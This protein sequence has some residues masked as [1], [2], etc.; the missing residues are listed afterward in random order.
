MTRRTQVMTTTEMQT[1]VAQLRMVGTAVNPAPIV[2]LKIS[3][4]TVETVSIPGTAISRLVIVQGKQT[5]EKPSLAGF[6]LILKTEQLSTAT[7][8]RLQKNADIVTLTVITQHQTVDYDI[9][10]SPLSAG[11]LENVAQFWTVTSGQLEIATKI[12]RF[13]DWHEILAATANSAVLKK[14]A[15][16][17]SAKTSYSENECVV[18][19]QTIITAM[20]SE[21][22]EAVSTA[23][24]VVQRAPTNSAEWTILIYQPDEA[25]TTGHDVVELEAVSDAQLLAMPVRVAASTAQFW[26]GLAWLFYQRSLDRM[27]ETASR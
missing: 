12:R 9:P 27:T 8:D 4:K 16:T 15:V 18:L 5:T 13:Y 17:L 21:R 25:G 20:Q 14:M 1:L 10:W 7:I 22:A 24:L 3:F 23:Y 11:L 6:D 19:I 26:E 2:Q